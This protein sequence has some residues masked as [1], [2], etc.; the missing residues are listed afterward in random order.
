LTINKPVT[1]EYEGKAND[2]SVADLESYTF[3]AG[4]RRYQDMGCQGYTCEGSTIVQP[5]KK[6]P[7]GELTSPETAAN[8]A[9]S[10]IRIRMEHA[11]GGVKRYRMVKT[12]Y[13]S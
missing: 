6:P 9:I 1:F 7:G 8:H 3:P 10:S 4:S 13:A 5:K 2:K 11:I 12:R